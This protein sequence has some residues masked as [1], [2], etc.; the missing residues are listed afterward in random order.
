MHLFGHYHYSSFILIFY[1]NICF[2][3]FS[4]F[5]GLKYVSV[6]IINQCLKHT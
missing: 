5:I 1:M 2:F 4:D 3:V 6:V